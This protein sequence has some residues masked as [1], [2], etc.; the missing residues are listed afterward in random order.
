M[1]NFIIRLLGGVPSSLHESLQARFNEKEIELQSYKQFAETIN[2]Y[3]GSSEAWK[4]QQ[5]F[6][7]LMRDCDRPV[8]KDEAFNFSQESLIDDY[9]GRVVDGVKTLVDT[10]PS[11]LA[12]QEIYQNEDRLSVA[13]GVDYLAEPRN[14]K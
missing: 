6:R 3:H 13:R 8:Y 5:E 9:L 12:G 1:F 11:N 2:K 10:V 7:Q 4:A 14:G